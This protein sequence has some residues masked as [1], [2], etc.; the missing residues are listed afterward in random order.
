LKTDKIDKLATHKVRQ[1]IVTTGGIA[2]LKKTPALEP[3]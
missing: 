3:T 1:I 2:V